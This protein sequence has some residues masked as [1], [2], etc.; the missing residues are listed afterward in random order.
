MSYLNLCRACDT[1]FSSVAAFDRHRTGTHD[2]SFLEGV[3]LCHKDGRRCMDPDEMLEA[4]ME[5]DAQGRWKITPSEAQK[6]FYEAS[7]V[8][9][10][11]A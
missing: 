2:Y 1:D 10:H 11:R 7:K 6:A 9:S 3:E 8:L 4:R 5:V